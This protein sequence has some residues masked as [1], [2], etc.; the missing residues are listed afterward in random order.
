[1]EKP[2]GNSTTE[3]ARRRT[4]AIFGRALS[5]RMAGVAS[6]V[7]KIFPLVGQR[8]LTLGFERGASDRMTHRNQ[9]EISMLSGTS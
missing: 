6:P 9:F 2:G 4:H 7:R 5:A 1:M 3:M 8:L